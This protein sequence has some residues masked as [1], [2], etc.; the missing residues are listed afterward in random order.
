M[1]IQPKATKSKNIPIDP[2][3]YQ[4]NFQIQIYFQKGDN[5]KFSSRY[6]YLHARF[7][8]TDLGDKS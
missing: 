2:I 3:A 5:L 6:Q 4:N 8:I 1:V 7:D